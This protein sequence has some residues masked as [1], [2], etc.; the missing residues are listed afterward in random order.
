MGNG[1]LHRHVVE[2]DGCLYRSLDAVRG[3]YLSPYHKSNIIDNPT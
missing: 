3:D 2:R 1:F